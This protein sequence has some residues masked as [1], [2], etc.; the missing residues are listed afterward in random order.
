V[1]GGTSVSAP[2]LAGI[3]NLAGSATNVDDAL[4]TIYANVINGANHQREQFPR[5]SFG[6][7]G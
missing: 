2:S 3:L 6:H 4:A 5:H 7:R 1:F